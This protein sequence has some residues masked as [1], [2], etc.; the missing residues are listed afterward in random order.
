M[1]LRRRPTGGLALLLVAALLGSVV[2]AWTGEDKEF[3]LEEFY[4]IKRSVTNSKVTKMKASMALQHAREIGKK[5]HSSLPKT[6]TFYGQDHYEQSF[7]SNGKET[8]SHVGRPVRLLA[9]LFMHA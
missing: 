7:D 4:D 9:S 5:L 1:C 6:P 2:F 3:S 8:W